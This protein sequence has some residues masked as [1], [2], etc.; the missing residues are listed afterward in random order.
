VREDFPGVEV[1]A[2]LISGFL[3]QT[4][5]YK[6]AEV[7][8]ISVLTVLLIGL[9]FAVLLPRLS[10]T[11]S[12]LAMAIV[13]ALLVAVNLIVWKTQHFVLNIA[14][15]LLML[16]LLYLLNMAW[17]FF[18]ETRSRRLITGLFGTYVPP[19]LV[20]EMRADPGRY[21]MRAENRE[22]SVMFCDMRGFTRM[23]E[24]MA[25]ADLQAFLNVF[26]SRLSEIIS[27]RRG[28]VDK[29]MGDCVMA[30]W[31]APV[32]T[33]DHAELAV[34]AAI[35]MVAAVRELNG[36]RQLAGLPDVQVGIGI[37]TGVMSVGDMG[38][39]VRRS[40]TVVGDAVNLASRIEGLG[41]HY[42][43]EI[44]ATEA[45]RRAAPGFA[46]QELDT[47]RVQGKA[48]TVRIFTP[49]GR[50]DSASPEVR[51]ELQQWDGV[52]SAYRLQDWLQGQ[53][54]LSALA[55]ANAKKVLYQLYAQRLAS[56]SLQPKD[57]EWDGAT[58]FDSK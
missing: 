46:W 48:R 4:I 24:Q 45:T 42:G 16:A 21:S 15:P 9:P 35:E 30:F 58:R 8:A 22:L 13:R 12:T 37:N 44:I 56:M 3:D 20:D 31:G 32:E 5:M 18:M 26:F 6:P 10:A 38:S 40:Y 53:A 7:L 43:V 2:N 29:Y 41:V 19:E 1:H 11:T 39:A 17:G 47:V 57:P 54:M 25:P 51:K 33:A 34:Q 50:S 49:I 27:A 23:A 55:A 14:A 36:R 52:L 28:T